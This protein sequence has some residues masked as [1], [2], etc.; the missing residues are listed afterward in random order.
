M[1]VL[2]L[3]SG[4]REHAM[5][6]KIAQS[7]L[8]NKL[9]I[10]PGN[11]GTKEVGTNLNINQT[12]FEAIKKAVLEHQIKLVI[13]GPEDPLVKGIHDFF[14]N[15]SDLKNIPVIGPQKYA[16]QLEGSK[17][18]A[19]EF[20]S[21]HNIPTAAY[22]SFTSENLDEGYAF[23]ETLTAPYVLKADGLA[24]GKGVLI[25]NDLQ[26][27]KNELTEM[28]ANKKFGAASSKVVIE[29]FLTG[30]ELSCFVLTDG[31]SYVT[32]PSA[33]DYKRIGE[34]DK[35]LNTGGMG[36]VSPVPFLTDAIMLKIETQVIK[37]TIDGFQ[38]DSIS[39]VGFVFIGLILDKGEIKVIEYNCR[40]GDPETEV[41]IPRIESDFLE[42]LIATGNKELH[43]K[44]IEFKKESACTVMLVSGGYPQAYE[45]GKEIFGLNTIENSIPFHAGTT[46]KDD[47]VVTNG[48]RVI[49]I[50]SYGTNFNEAL[51][52]SYKNIEKLCFEGMNYRKDIGFD[53]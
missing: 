40:M 53:L 25:L 33:K 13:V 4:G 26:E 20:M 47:K 36:A 43:T 48:G 28:L 35:G 19:K 37:P 17:E 21:R 49:A 38:K 31:K 32:L 34:G 51:K 30:I 5:A 1:N 24:A 6:W 44:T 10:A 29:E 52:Q 42:L 9:F 45:K 8:L 27:A 11:A 46:I 14:L 22:K 12:D 41:V 23:L 2:I 18:F 3:G 50:T 7:N 39:Y 16:A 15:D